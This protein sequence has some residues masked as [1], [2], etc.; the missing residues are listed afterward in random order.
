MLDRISDDLVVF[1]YISVL[2]VVAIYGLHRY[3]LVYLYLKHRHNNYQP[4]SQFN[5]LPRVTVQLPMYNEQVVAE[6]II[7][8]TCQIDY[9]REK[10]EIQV[11][12]DSTDDSARIARETCEKWAAKGYPVKYIH[13]ADRK[14]YKAGA[15]AEGLPQAS[16]EF[17]AIFDA[18]FLPPRDILYN[19][20]DYFTDDKVGLVQVRWDHLNRDASLLTKSQA[21]FLDGHFVIEHTARNRSGRFMH[22][23]GTAGVWRRKT[24]EDAGG[25][26]HDT[27]TE[28]LDLSYR[29]QMKGWQFVYLP[30]FCAPAELPPEMIG[31]KQQ[32]HRWT[33]GSVQTAIKLLPKVLRSKK[34]PLRIKTEAFFHLTNTIVYVLMVILT[35][36]MYPAFLSFYSPL[37][38]HSHTWGQSLFSL[39]LFVLATCSASTFFIVGQRELLGREAGWKALL[40]MP[41]LMALGVGI[42]LNNAK[43]VIEAIWGAIFR[44]PS[45]FIRTP[46]YGVTGLAKRT[47]Q[48]SSVWTLRKLSLPII[49]IAF[50]CYMSCWIFISIYYD[51]CMQAVPFLLIFAGGYFYVGFNSL[52]AL[53]K[54]QQEAKEAEAAAEAALVE[55]VGPIST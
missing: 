11:L 26:E 15:L 38:A 20:M 50:G 43:A 2:T 45:E 31:F 18:D 14:G 36:L 24:I 39:S 53:Y 41:I 16:G 12:D 13:R 48:C 32:A 10:F 6:R 9:P 52:Y 30:Q 51:F 29:A 8:A 34:L 40:Y 47:W 17:I 25:W 4:K 19:V 23:N 49:E 1:F 21:I 54:M 22:F 5:E 55:T 33:K 7:E 44:K 37:K 27:L 46:K 35:V 42:S 28:D 3:I